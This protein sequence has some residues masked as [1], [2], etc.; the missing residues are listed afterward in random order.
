MV[1]LFAVYYE[2]ML[3]HV[4]FWYYTFIQKYLLQVKNCILLASQSIWC[5]KSVCL[6]SW[7]VLGSFSNNQ[8]FAGWKKREKLILSQFLS[9]IF[10]PSKPHSKYRVTRS[11][12]Y[13]VH[14]C[15]HSGFAKNLNY[16]QS[17]RTKIRPLE[18]WNLNIILVGLC[19][20]IRRLY[21]Y[22]N[23]WIFRIPMLN[24]SG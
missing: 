5:Y 17:T 13:H 11:R 24:P 1:L 20:T 14:P 6:P 4:L 23:P 7:V 3:E 22:W 2:Y 18:N 10:Q 19:W 8:M 9:F 21:T 12:F 15:F 16:T